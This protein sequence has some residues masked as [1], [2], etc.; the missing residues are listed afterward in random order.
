[1]RSP[2]SPASASSATCSRSPRAR[3]RRA[4][5]DW[6]S[7]AP[8]ARRARV[9]ARG[10]PH[11]RL[12][13]QLDRLWRPRRSWARRW[14]MPSAR[15]SP[16]RRPAAACS[17][18][19]IPPAVRR[20]C[21]QCS[22]TKGSTDAAVIGEIES[23]A[24]REV[25]AVGSFRRDRERRPARVPR[26]ARPARS[27]RAS[28]QVRAADAR[29]GRAAVA[30]RIA[31]SSRC[32]TRARPSGTSRTRPGSSRPSCSRRDDRGVQPFDPAFTVLFN[33]YYNARRRPPSAARSAACSRG[34]PLDRGARLSRRTSTTRMLALL[35]A[36]RAR[37]R[38]CSRW[39]SSAC[40]TSS[41]TRS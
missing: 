12:G 30:P 18:P 10:N 23:G 26:R 21:W 36:G 2:T 19:A 5:C 1:M 32:P 8:A 9:R 40:T 33:S 28:S 7:R 16:I 14:A 6:K 22:A 11:R 3:G 37:R 20:R 4:A 25:V 39:S 15:C 24:P 41:S 13:A 17:W 35:A 38:G 34:P 27:R 31:P 29:A